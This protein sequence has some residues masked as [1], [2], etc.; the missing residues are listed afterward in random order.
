MTKKY[1][2]AKMQSRLKL[3]KF[4]EWQQEGFRIAST[5]LFPDTLKRNEMP[6]ENY[7]KT[8]FEISQEQIALAGY[9]MGEMLNQIFD[10][11]ELTREDYEKDKNEYQKQSEATESTIGQGAND[12]W[13]WVKTRSALASTNDLRDST[14]NV[15]VENSVVTLKGTVASRAQKEKAVEVAK[16]VDG[17]K[18]IK[19]MIKIQPNNSPK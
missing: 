15:D 3:R 4:D 7:K 14:I 16:N 1:P 2:F 5:K 8:A 17:V 11:R 13:L 10:S 6:S 12:K 19:N 9:R 18:A